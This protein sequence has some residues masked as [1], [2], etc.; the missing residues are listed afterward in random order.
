[1]ALTPEAAL[2]RIAF[3]LERAQAPTYKVRAFRGAAATLRGLP[4][5]ELG[6]LMSSGGLR[7]LDGIGE[8]TER[9][10]VEASEGTVPGYLARL[11]DE[12]VAAGPL[13]TG[14]E[15]LRAVLRGDCHTHS[16]WSDGGS[17]IE[18]MARTAHALGH[19]YVVLTDHSARLTVAHGLD[20]E[21]LLHQLDVV[22][23]IN[24]TLAPFRILTGME[25][26]ILDDGSLDADDDVLGRLDLVVGSVHS[27]LKMAAGDMTRRM[28]AAV[29]SP[30]VDVL[31]HCTGRLVSGKRGE[32]AFDADMVFAACAQ[33]DTAVEINCRPERLDPPR[34]LLRLAVEWG[35]RFS[36]D[37]DAH[38]P[39]QLDWQ[40]YGCAR[41]VECG[42]DADRVVNTWDAD[43][44][45]EWTAAH[46]AA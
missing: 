10:I 4:D 3:L 8:A 1:M 6:R 24:E 44:L 34:R 13:A 9:V 17:P 45:L 2:D 43:R 22:A 11:E 40:P 18:E 7:S 39:G 23:G 41:A 5:G 31:G 33:T 19:D 30:H 27:K 12:A 46:A 38:A 20:R 26:D 16:D 14:G 32:S 29:A 35:C 37:T 36:I 15:A 42:V 28:V 25:V 21:R